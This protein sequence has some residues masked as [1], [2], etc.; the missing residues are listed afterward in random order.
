MAATAEAAQGPPARLTVGQ[1]S[2]RTVRLVTAQAHRTG[3]ADC[4]SAAE[5]PASWAWNVTGADVSLPS[6]ASLTWSTESLC[7]CSC[8]TPGFRRSDTSVQA[9][10][11]DRPVDSCNDSA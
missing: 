7:V 2:C 4:S 11:Q 5:G 9:G 6:S 1:P 10:G 3:H 8:S